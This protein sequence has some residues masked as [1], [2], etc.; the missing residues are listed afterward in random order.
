MNINRYQQRGMSGLAL[1]FLIVI[2]IFVLVIFFKLFPLYMENWTVASALEKIKEEPKIA[3]KTDS[4]IQNMFLGYLSDKDVD[5]E[6]FNRE[7]IGQKITIIRDDGS[8][9]ITVTYQQTK[10]LIGNISFL[11]NFENFVSAP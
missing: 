6:L 2:L 8:V 5:E 10:P 7:N 1:L 3:Q 9:E 4:A 11:I